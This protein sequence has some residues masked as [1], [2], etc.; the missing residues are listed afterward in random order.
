MAT[1]DQD[2]Q[3]RD[4]KRTDTPGTRVS[5]P[6]RSHLYPCEIG[7]CLRDPDARSLRVQSNIVVFIPTFSSMVPFH[8][9]APL[10]FALFCG[11]TGLI[12]ALALILLWILVVCCVPSASRTDS[13]RQTATDHVPSREAPRG[14]IRGLPPSNAPTETSRSVRRRRGPLSLGMPHILRSWRR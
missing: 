11:A 10:W 1:L 12:V 7:P 2:Q 13:A 8:L 14:D 5:R 9:G 6:H 4:E 3:G